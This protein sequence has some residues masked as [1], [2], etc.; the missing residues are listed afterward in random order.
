MAL[1]GLP[2]RDRA[3][4]LLPAAGHRL[5]PGR[6]ADLAGRLV[7]QDAEQDRS[8]SAKVIGAGPGRRR[9]SASSSAPAAPT[10]PT[11]T[12]AC[13]PRDSGRKATADQ[14]INRAAAASSAGWSA[15]AAL[16]AGGA[17]HQ[18]RRPR[19]PGAVPVHP[20]ATPTC[21]ELNTWAPEAARGACRQLPQLN[22]VSSDQQSQ[23]RGGQPDHRPRRR[24]RAS[25]SRRPTS[26][27]RST[28]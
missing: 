18:R 8:R 26:T 5:H 2:L 20:V 4:R 22:D 21:D 25:A 13:K 7:R 15:C 1:G 12:S 10:R 14:I 17:G 6:R 16:P 27:R 19:R 9:A 28:T 3:D 24:R 11:S 23:A